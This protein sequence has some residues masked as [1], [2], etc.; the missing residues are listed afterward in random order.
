[1]RRRC[2]DPNNPAYPRYG[3]RGITVSRQF[4]T[5]EGFIGCLGPCPAGF[6]LERMDN[7]KGY[8]PSNTVWAHPKAQGRNKRNNQLLT[9]D[10]KTQPL[11]A[12]A[13]DLGITD[14]SLRTRLERWTLEKA[15]S[16]RRTRNWP[17]RKLAP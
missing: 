5:F 1:M 15:L 12:W 6:T 17:P 8:T 3:G 13:E 10:G 2:E 16:L 7:A 4:R 11:S 14:G 9:F